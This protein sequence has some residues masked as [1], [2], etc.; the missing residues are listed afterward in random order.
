MT[1]P[2]SDPNP[3]RTSPVQHDARRSLGRVVESVIRA[4]R[5][6]ILSSSEPETMIGN[7]G[8][9]TAEETLEG[10]NT[11]CRKVVP[12]FDRLSSPVVMIEE[13][14]AVL[15]VGL[16]LSESSSRLSTKASALFRRPINV[17]SQCTPTIHH[18]SLTFNL[19]NVIR[20][21]KLHLGI[22]R[23]EWSIQ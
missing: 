11:T 9:Y 14:C 1:T 13:A 5:I 17:N 18:P 23:V 22:P 4:I 10:L 8:W 6:R 19:H 15:I 3:P 21:G 7:L 12:D 20:S 16:R 2:P